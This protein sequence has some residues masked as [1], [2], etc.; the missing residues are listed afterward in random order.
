[1]SV[2]RDAIISIRPDA[3]DAILNGTKTVELRRKIPEIAIGARL[4]IYA[5]RPVAAVVGIVAVTAVTK[6]HPPT[7]WQKHKDSADLD[8]VS[9]EKYF[10]GAQEAI[11]ITLKSPERVGP[12]SVDQLRKILTHFNPPRVLVRL[13]ADDAEA[14]WSACKGGRR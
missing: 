11:A 10:T 3:A 9:F 2:A 6:A 13:T 4:W 8:H 5:T 14:L 12:I 1:M 7:I